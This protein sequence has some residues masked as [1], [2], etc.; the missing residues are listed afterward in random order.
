MGSVGRGHATYQDTG[1][2]GA[3]IVNGAGSFVTGALGLPPGGNTV[4]TGGQQAVMLGVQSVSAGGFTGLQS[5]VEGHS[6]ETAAWSAVSAAGFN[7]AG[8]QMSG[9][10][11]FSNL[12]LPVQAVVQLGAENAGNMVNSA[13][14]DSDSATAPTTPIA[15]GRLTH[16][17]VPANTSGDTSYIRTNILRQ[18]P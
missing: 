7:F 8:G 15:R 10:N 12:S 13:I 6:A 5:H 11:T 2:V 3:A 9:S 17:G 4:L 16:A 18:R 1:N 14:Q